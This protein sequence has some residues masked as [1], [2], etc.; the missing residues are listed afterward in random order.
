[1]KALKLGVPTKPT[2][3]A[4]THFPHQPRHTCLADNFKSCFQIFDFMLHLHKSIQ[5]LGLTHV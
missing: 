3:L 4:P 5:N 2:H 1:M